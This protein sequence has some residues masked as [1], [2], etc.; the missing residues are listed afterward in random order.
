MRA[1]RLTKLELEVIAGCIEHALAGEVSGGPLERLEVGET[2]RA[3]AAA[4]SAIRKIGA[5]LASRER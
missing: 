1:K 5:M 3:M 4:E 2:D